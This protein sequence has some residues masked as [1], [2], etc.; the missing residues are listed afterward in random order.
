MAPQ[1]QEQQL[2]IAK[3][4][5]KAASLKKAWWTCPRS[6]SATKMSFASFLSIHRLRLA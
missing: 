4:R 1:Q 3:K 5:P 2:Q 6:V